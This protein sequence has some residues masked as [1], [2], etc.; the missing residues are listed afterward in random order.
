MTRTDLS[1][2]NSSTLKSVYRNE[3]KPHVDVLVPHGKPGADAGRAIGMTEV[4]SSR[5]RH[6]FGDLKSDPRSRGP[7]RGCAAALELKPSMP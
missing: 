4:T 2:L 6:E 5:S 1:L 7:S 3:W